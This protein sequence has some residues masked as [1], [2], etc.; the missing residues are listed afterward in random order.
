MYR[1][2]LVP[3]DGSTFSEHA[4][5]LATPLARKAGSTLH[6][7]LVHTPLALHTSDIAPIRLTEQWEDEH[8]GM[9]RHY[10]DE[11]AE[12]LRAEGLDVVTE[13]R[14]GDVSRELTSL[15]GSMD[16]LVVATHGRGGLG[17]A[18]LGSVADFLIRHVTAPI[19]LIRPEGGDE[20]PP[21]PVEP[22]HVLAAT[23]GSAASLATV[24]HAAELARLFRA[25]LTL[26]RV[27]AFPG[28]LA[29]PYIPHTAEM[30]REAVERG[31]AEARES[32]DALAD[33]FHDLTVHTRVAH[34]FQ[35]ARGILQAIVDVGADVVAVGTHRRTAL[36]R[37]VL[38]STADKVVRASPVPVLVGHAAD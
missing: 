10:L 30:D 4:L 16:M 14:E 3:L 12:R 20:P 7:V 18:W 17:R 22:R 11:R 24:E 26:L 9:E 19:Y 28:G 2:L 37:T 31:D 25:R 38:G 15:A 34:A 5:A 29:S 33:R 21:P 36:G 1:K 27:V 23:D 32:L 13:V 35:P 6:L 8:R